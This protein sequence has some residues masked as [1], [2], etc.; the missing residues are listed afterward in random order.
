MKLNRI[1]GFN[2]SSF[3]KSAY[4]TQLHFQCL[5][6]SQYLFFNIY[7]IHNFGNSVYIVIQPSSELDF[8]FVLHKF[9][10]FTEDGVS[11]GAAM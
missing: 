9:W 6:P 3:T 4:L 8:S 2:V 10:L 7:N 5:I 11:Y 1:Y